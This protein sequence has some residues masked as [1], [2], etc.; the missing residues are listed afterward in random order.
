MP[1]DRD[2]E[3]SGRAPEV[4]PRVVLEHVP[5]TRRISRTRSVPIVRVIQPLVAPVCRHQQPFLGWGYG[6]M[7]AATALGLRALRVRRGASAST[8]SPSAGRSS[9]AGPGS[10][11]CAHRGLGSRGWPDGLG[12][13]AGA[14]PSTF[15]ACSPLGARWPAPPPPRGEEVSERVI[16]VYESVLRDDRAGEWPVLEVVAEVQTPQLGPRMR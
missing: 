6:S 4:L 7:I 11:P 8:T 2:F 12:G 9:R 16:T 3:D 10:W 13:W 1:V 5:W 14:P 15:N